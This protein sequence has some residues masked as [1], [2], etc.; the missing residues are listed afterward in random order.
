MS[1][2]AQAADQGAADDQAVGD[3][4]QGPHLLGSEVSGAV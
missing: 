1:H 3:R 4:R 2:V